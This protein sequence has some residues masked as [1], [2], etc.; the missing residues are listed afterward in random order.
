[1]SAQNDC[2]YIY[3]GINIC[4]IS[5]RMWFKEIVNKQQNINMELIILVYMYNIIINN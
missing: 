5:R 1:M 3:Q 2:L 4:I